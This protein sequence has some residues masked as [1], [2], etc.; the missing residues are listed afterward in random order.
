MKVKAYRN[1][2]IDVWRTALLAAGYFPLVYVYMFLAFAVM[3]SPPLVSATVSWCFFAIYGFFTLAWLRHRV[4][5]PVVQSAFVPVPAVSCL[6]LF[7]LAST[8]D[9]N[10]AIQ[11]LLVLPMHCIGLLTSW[12]YFKCRGDD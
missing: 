6:F 3:Y 5:R 7:D 9:I 10:R 4:T 1:V 2:D 8:G 12:L 11:W